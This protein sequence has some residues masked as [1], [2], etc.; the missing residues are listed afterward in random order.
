QNRSAA[1]LPKVRASF[2][3]DFA[4]VRNTGGDRVDLAKAAMGMLGNDVSQG[5]FAGAGRTIENQRVEPVG[6]QHTT[7]QL[8]RA[9]EMLLA[10]EFLQ[11]PRPHSRRQRLGF[12]QIRFMEC[13]KQDDSMNTLQ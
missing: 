7:Q 2:F 1:G 4:N 6:L 11:R 9:D 8:G 13:L 3:Q 5:S 10:D 12:S